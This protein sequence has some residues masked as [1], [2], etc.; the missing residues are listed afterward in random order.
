[1]FTGNC[2]WMMRENE[3]KIMFISDIHGAKATTEKGLN[4]FKKEKAD[5]LV[6]L[7]DYLNHG[8][9]NALDD[10]YDPEVVAGLL[11]EHKDRILAIRGNC[12]SEVDQMLFEFPMM[13]SY[14]MIQLEGRKI[15]C[16]HGHLFNPSKLP[17]L[18]DGD[19]FVS[20]HTHIQLLGNQ[21]GIV[22]MNPGS[23]TIPRG[24]TEA[25]YIVLEQKGSDQCRIML[26]NLKGKTLKTL[27]FQSL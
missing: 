20:G 18:T 5:T 15:F 9:R 3:M 24:G 21:D 10:S 7:G 2:Y 23:L 26:K 14:S 25:G 17:P 19:I 12:D 22:V 8:P 4:A 27:T 13:D 11:N 16:T 6:M 1:L